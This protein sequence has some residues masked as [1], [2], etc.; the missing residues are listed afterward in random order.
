MVL[1]VYIL[2]KDVY[3]LCCST[4]SLL[5]RDLL[6]P[7]AP[8]DPLELQVLMGHRVL[9]EELATLVQWEKR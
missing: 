5:S 3:I 9:P 7:Q 4:A 6:V 8:E 2:G 1:P